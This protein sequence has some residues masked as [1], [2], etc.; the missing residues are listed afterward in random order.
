MEYRKVNFCLFF[1]TFSLFTL[2]LF[3]TPNSVKISSTLQTETSTTKIHT[4]IL[5]TPKKKDEIWKILYYVK[6]PMI[7]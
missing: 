4:N 1:F 7:S 3:E 6:T 2:F 5:K